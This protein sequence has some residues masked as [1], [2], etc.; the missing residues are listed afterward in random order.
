MP[1]ARELIGKF[2]DLKTLPHVAIKVT[3]MINS[4]SST[5]QDFE[6][7]IKLDPI[8]MVRL[9]KLVNSPYFGL[10][11]KVETVSKAVVFIGMKN[12]RNL[13]A[14]EA[15]RDLFKEK[16]GDDSGFSRPGLWVH[17]ATVAILSQMIAKRIFGQDGENEFLAGIIHDIGL[18][19][20]DQLVPEELREAARNYK[21]GDQPLTVY[22]QEVIETHHAKVGG[23]L[24][25]DWNMPEDVVLGIKKHHDTSKEY[26]IPGVVSIIHIAEYIA[27]R[28][29][30]GAIEG[31]ADPLPPYLTPHMKERMAEY[32]V[33]IK[34]LPGE[35]SKANDLYGDDK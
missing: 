4:E 15:L 22:E 17:S 33:L 27:N 16:E 20:E 3:Q 19:V 34:D 13:V 26:P 14:V 12:L 31:K 1:S 2:S 21:N 10:A 5:I 29:K 7:V 35:M 11:N 18:I 25:L 9:L 8:L 24:V 28:M 6:E 23:M 32:K 30:Y